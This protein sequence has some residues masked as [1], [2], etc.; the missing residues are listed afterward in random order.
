M[1]TKFQIIS[2]T[3]GSSGTNATLQGST[4]EV[5]NKTN[6]M[7]KSNRSFHL[8]FW[9]ITHL[10]FFSSCYRAAKAFLKSKDN[11][12]ATFFFRSFSFISSLI[13]S[14]EDDSC[15]V[16]P[17]LSNFSKMEIGAAGYASFIIMPLF[18]LS[19]I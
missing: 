10:D 15:F 1:S 2:K 14:E 6:T 5:N 12:S 16:I 9:S 3:T 11:F 19:I 18:K 7:Y 17:F 13:S 4:R 8:L